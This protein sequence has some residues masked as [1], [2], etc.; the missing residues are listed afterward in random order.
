[1][2]ITKTVYDYFGPKQITR[3]EFIKQWVDHFQQFYHLGENV[4]QLNQLAAMQTRITELAG[5]KWDDLKE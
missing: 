4:D 5:R 3:A 2:S 1:M